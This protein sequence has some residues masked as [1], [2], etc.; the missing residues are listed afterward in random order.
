MEPT[1]ATV[2]SVAKKVLDKTVGSL[3][4]GLGFGAAYA[5]EVP[6][7]G[8]PIK[9][10]NEGVSAGYNKAQVRILASKIVAGKTSAEAEMTKLDAE[11]RKHLA[12]EV[13]KVQ[14]GLAKHEDVNAK[15]EIVTR[16][17]GPGFGA[18]LMGQ[19]S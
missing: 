3:G 10:L 6:V 16:A 1:K 4:F 14:A 15:G 9:S 17:G 13:A 8:A 18:G 12:D 19:P 2:G 5:A 11:S 7:L